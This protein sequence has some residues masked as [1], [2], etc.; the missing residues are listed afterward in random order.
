MHRLINDVLQ[1]SQICIPH[2]LWKKE[3]MLDIKKRKN[4][5]YA[6]QQKYEISNYIHLLVSLYM[7]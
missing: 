4:N 6:I 3:S 7:Y 2:Y 5:I 1:E